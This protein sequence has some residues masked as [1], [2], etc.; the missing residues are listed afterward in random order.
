[1]NYPQYPG[2]YQ[3]YPAYPAAT[4]APSGATAITAGVL[5]CVGA[6]GELFGGL[7]DLAI[8]II[9]WEVFGLDGPLTSGWYHTFTIVLGVV[10]LVA[11]V[12]LGVGGVGLF[13]RKSFGRVL[14]AVGCAV[15]VVAGIV[16]LVLTQTML[17][18]YDSTSVISGGIGGLLGLIFPVA[19]AILV[20]LPATSRWLAH[21]PAMVPPPYYANPG[22]PQGVPAW[23]GVDAQPPVSA[24]QAGFPTPQAGWGQ[25]GAA[26]QPGPS[27]PPT[28]APQGAWAPPA[29]DASVPG[30]SLTTQNAQPGA[31][32][33][34]LLDGQ[35]PTPAVWGAPSDAVAAPDNGAWSPAEPQAAGNAPAAIGRNDE[36]V[37]RPPS[38]MP[39][40]LAKPGDETIRRQPES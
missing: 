31:A 27:W 23:P 19:T 2:G 34:G 38:S 28:F 26:G 4:Q 33:P 8:G 10:G 36:T 21:T 32:A 6:V 39:P 3:P 13:S 18:S 15:V 7:A 24:Q 12:L 40:A 37:L 25:P 5:A 17:D 9:G 20:L 30:P 35:P 11:A 14:V 1:M 16:G 22:F 29:P